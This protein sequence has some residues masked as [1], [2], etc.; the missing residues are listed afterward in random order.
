MRTF[1]APHAILLIALVAG[2]SLMPASSARPATRAYDG[3]ACGPVRDSASEHSSARVDAM[4]VCLLNYER[5][6][7]GLAPLAKVA[8]LDLAS[9]RHS[10]DMV[11]RR[12]FEHVTPDGVRP[13]ARIVAAGFAAGP[14]RITGENIAWGKGHAGT[15]AEIV[16]AWMNS[17]GHRANILRAGF[18]G[19]GVGLTVGAAPVRGRSRPGSATYT[20]D[21]GG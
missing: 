6:R 11:A 9:Q 3:A 16:N 1:G 18:T 5:G 21:F 19:V 10:D 15:P 8:T 2:V 7:H 17:P 13:E 12:Y 14:G 4:V 20:T